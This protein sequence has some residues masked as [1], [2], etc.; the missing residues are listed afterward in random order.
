MIKLTLVYEDREC[1]INSLRIAYIIKAKSGTYVGF[2]GDD[3]DN[4]YVK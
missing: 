4:L 2:G 3:D 1:W